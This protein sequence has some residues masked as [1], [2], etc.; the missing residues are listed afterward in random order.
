MLLVNENEDNII[1][2]LFIE[3][4]IIKEIF[5]NKNQLSEYIKASSIDFIIYG[6]NLDLI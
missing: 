5:K 4:K 1:T 3:N 2:S 6:I